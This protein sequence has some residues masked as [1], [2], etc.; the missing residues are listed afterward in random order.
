MKLKYDAIIFDFD[1]V[2]VDTV[3]IKTQGFIKLFEKYG[4]DVVKKVIDYHIENGGVSRSEKFKYYYKHFLD[5][6]LSKVKLDIL[7][8][9]YSVLTMKPSIVAPWIK[10]AKEFLEANYKD[11]KFYIVS[12]VADTDLQLIIK[13]RK[14]SKYFV[15]IYGSPPP[16]EIILNSIIRKNYYNHE[17][18]LYIGDALSD[19]DVSRKVGIKFLGLAKTPVFPSNV[20]VIADLTRRSWDGFQRQIY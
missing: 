8:A 14:M 10:G 16:K 2:L 11:N 5:K 3:D 7:C 19:L 17:K 9:Q 4:D 6:P 18:T 15:K 13:K 20:S 1:G 12:G